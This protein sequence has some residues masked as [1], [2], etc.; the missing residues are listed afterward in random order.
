MSWREYMA[1]MGDV[2]KNMTVMDGANELERM[3]G[4]YV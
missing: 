2:V 4:R 1:G 3:Y